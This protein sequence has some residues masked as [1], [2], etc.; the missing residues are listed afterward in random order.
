DEDVITLSALAMRMAASEHR[1]GAIFAIGC[2]PT[3]LDELIALATSGEVAPLLVIGVPVGFVGAAESKDRLRSLPAGV[4]P[5]ISNVGERGGSAVAAA[6][7][8]ALVRL[9]GENH[10]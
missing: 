7:V 5:S 3:A 2:A 4:L 6:I 9:S 8:N 10:E 1:E